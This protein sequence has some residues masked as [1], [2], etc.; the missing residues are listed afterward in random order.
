MH[1]SHIIIIIIGRVTA[2]K[3][4]SGPFGFD[5]DGCHPILFNTLKK[6]VFAN[7]TCFRLLLNWT[8]QDGFNFKS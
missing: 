8:N 5:R 7:K 2:V 6:T 3:G 4:V 1:G